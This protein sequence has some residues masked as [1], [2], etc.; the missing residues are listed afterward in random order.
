MQSEIVVKK[1]SEMILMLKLRRFRK[2]DKEM[3][4]E[5]RRAGKYKITRAG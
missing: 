5:V 4:S 1:R 3:D 2:M